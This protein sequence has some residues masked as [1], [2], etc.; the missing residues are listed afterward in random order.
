MLITHPS[1][2]KVRMSRAIP[3]FLMCFHGVYRLYLHTTRNCQMCVGFP[4]KVAT[5]LCSTVRYRILRGRNKIQNSFRHV[6]D[7]NSKDIYSERNDAVWTVSQSGSRSNKRVQTVAAPYPFVHAAAI[8]RVPSENPPT[9]LFPSLRPQ[10]WSLW[11]TT[12]S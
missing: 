9:H 5:H 11:C 6:M 7:S 8:R 10:R 12:Y 3:L 2:D 1:R 4:T